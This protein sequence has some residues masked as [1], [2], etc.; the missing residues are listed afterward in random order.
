MLAR[1]G[2]PRP[3]TDLARLLPEL[4]ARALRL[5]R[6]PATAD[7]VVQDTLERA[8]RFGHQY[9]R[10]TNFG[11]WCNQILFSVFVTRWRRRRRERNALEQLGRD[12]CAWSKPSGFSAPDAGPGALSRA[13]RRS[14]DALPEGFRAVVEM[15]DLEDRSYRDAA[16]ELGVPVG[17]VMSRLHRGRKLLAD[18][19]SGRGAGFPGDVAHA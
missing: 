7:D 17:T 15:V 9:E 11:A 3:D 14:L 5:C 16:H 1:D 18:E 19:I 8:L 4:R 12:P 13:T 10:G 6:D 2:H